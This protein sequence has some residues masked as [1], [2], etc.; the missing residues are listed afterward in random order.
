M[1][2]ENCGKLVVWVTGLL[3]FSALVGGGSALGQIQ[4]QEVRVR[5]TELYNAG[6]TLMAKGEAQQAIQKFGEAI[7]ID[8]TFPYPYINRAVA[9][10]TLSRYSEGLADAEKAIGLHKEGFFPE[11]YL[12][13]AYQVKGM[14]FQNEGKS[15]A[16]LE[17]FSKA[18]DLNP[19]D[20][21]FYNSRGNV[22]RVLKN[23]E[24]ALKDFDKGISLNATIPQLFAN[25]GSVHMHLKNYELSIKD[26]DEAIRLDKNLASAFLNR[27]NTHAETKNYEAALN[28]YNQAISIGQKPEYFYNRGRVYMIQKK[29]DLA[30]NDNTAALALDPNFAGAYGN[31]AVAYGHLGKSA[32]AVDDLR[33]AVGFRPDSALLRYNL[34]H[35]L[36]LTGHFAAAATEATR[37][38]EM[39]PRWRE[40]Y[41][42]RSVINAKSGNATRAKADRDT[43]SKLVA[44]DRP[45]EGELVFTFNVQLPDENDQ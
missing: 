41:I 16:A 19:S 23:Y 8:D 21:K 25:R 39:A 28:D 3:L 34:S 26:L 13:I 40:A 37:A 7:A 33:K 2:F 36:Y 42:L 35:Q 27:G 15:E 9:Y 12:A 22:H 10:V 45:F 38:I 24:A 5:A 11:A 32:L 44:G 31:R 30:V 18:V 4:P 1:R 6:T 17:S 29:Y 14:V 20:P 43:A